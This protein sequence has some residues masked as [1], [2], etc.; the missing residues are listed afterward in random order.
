LRERKKEQTRHAIG[1][2]ATRLFIER[3]FDAVT[4]AEVA[5]AADVA[6]NT[7]FNYFPTKEDLFFDRHAAVE[8]QFSRI[9]R[10][11]APQESVVDA[12]RRDFLEA[13]DHAE[14]RIGLS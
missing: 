3:G 10:T 14:P 13:V 5:R 7:V 9:V 1:E 4:V 8:D 2:T 6:E 12:L 11:R